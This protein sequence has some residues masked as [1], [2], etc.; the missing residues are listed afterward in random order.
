MP[1]VRRLRHRLGIILPSRDRDGRLLSAKMRRV[2][3]A[4]VADWFSRAFAGSTEDRLQTRARLRG[5]WLSGVG[6]TVEEIEEVWAYCMAADF[7]RHK[8]GLIR[9]AEWVANESD[10]DAV[11]ILVDAA[12]ELVVQKETS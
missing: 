6:V 3:R 11:A 2:I 9:L 4:A 1:V 10:Q 7:R 5:R 12:L 8:P